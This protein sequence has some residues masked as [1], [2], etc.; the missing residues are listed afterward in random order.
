[1]T[2][3]KNVDISYAKKEHKKSACQEDDRYLL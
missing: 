1:M 3:M 2:F